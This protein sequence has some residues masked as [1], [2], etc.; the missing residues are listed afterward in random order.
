M[1]L[2]LLVHASECILY[3]SASRSLCVG[4]SVT[5][6]HVVGSFLNV[7]DRL[8]FSCEWMKA[9]SYDG[10]HML[11]PQMERRWLFI[12]ISKAYHGSNI[13]QTAHTVPCLYFICP[14]IPFSCCCCC[15]LLYCLCC[16][17]LSRAAWRHMVHHRIY[18]PS[19]H[20]YSACLGESVCALCACSSPLKLNKTL[21]DCVGGK[22]KQPSG[23][24]LSY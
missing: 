9:L 17:P 23:G 13:I 16:L 8:D 24:F 15:R 10:V 21:W 22:K 1:L 5:L 2:W 4:L 12:I 20:R 3:T 6:F 18:D 7:D 19:Q 14:L 11:V